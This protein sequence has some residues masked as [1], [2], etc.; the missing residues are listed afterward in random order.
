MNKKQFDG[1][2]RDL[3]KKAKSR[4]YV[5]NDEIND[6]LTDDFD[7]SELDQI[8]DRLNDLKIDFFDDEDT[9]KQKMELTRKKKKVSAKIHNH[10]ENEMRKRLAQDG[11]S[12]K[13][14]SAGPEPKSASGGKLKFKPRSQNKN[15]IS[16]KGKKS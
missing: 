15:L 1:L 8:Y 12:L 9:A 11:G 6:M 16:K 2:I 3:K 13:H 5:L 14:I 7:M 4:G 10:I